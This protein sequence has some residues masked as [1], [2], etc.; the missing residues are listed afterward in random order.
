ML[1]RS[2][3]GVTSVGN[4]CMLMAVVHV[5]HDCILGNNVVVANNAVMGGHVTID[6][7]AV[8]GGAAAIHQFVHIGRAAMI[9]GV[10][11]VPADV[12]P[13]GYVFG[14]RGKLVGLNV[15]G[16]RRRGFDKTAIQQFHIAFKALYRNEGVFADRVQEV[17]TEFGE[18]PLVAEVL[19]FI[20][21]AGPRGL[22]QPEL[23][24]ATFE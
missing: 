13:F 3:R 19:A 23:Q 17:R 5:A 12:I 9:G 2:G 24:N 22:V 16:L 14:N 10:T 4:E 18:N 1:F 8:I 21:A 6:D 11:G 15:V 20:D 7:F